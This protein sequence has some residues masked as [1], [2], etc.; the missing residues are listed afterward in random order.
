MA[1]TDTHSL[2]ERIFL[3]H[4]TLQSARLPICAQRLQALLGNCSRKQLT[5]TITHLRD[6]LQAPL[7]YDPHLKGW[8]YDRNAPA[9]ELPGI[10][11]TAT[12]LH[13]LL[14]AEDLLAQADPGVLHDQIRPLRQRIARLLQHATREPFVRLDAIRITTPML[15]RPHREVFAAI[16]Q[17]TLTARQLQFAYRARSHP[18]DESR[19]VSPLR[20]EHYRGNW[21]LLAWCHG[22]ADWRRFAL[23]RITDPHV[24]E[25]AVDYPAQEPTANGFGLFDRTAANLA[26]L[27]FTAERARWIADE[28]WHPDQQSRWLADGRFELSIPFGDPTELILDIQRYGP[29]VEVIAPEA[30]RQML[31]E[32]LRMA[33][34]NY[35][36]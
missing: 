35:S 26:V 21:Y 32:R 31:I 23:E 1:R 30:L 17:A 27:R 2:I 20:L 36:P 29:D 25:R 12:E 6:V 13:A 34:R 4:R 5:R 8:R 28:E 10:W 3:I 24:C 33:L 22:R 7:E 18:Q 19:S 9:F 16:A 14:A 15:R 11:F